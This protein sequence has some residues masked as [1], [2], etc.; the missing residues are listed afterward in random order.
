VF[1]CI[2]LEEIKEILCKSEAL[3]PLKP[4]I[5]NLISSPQAARNWPLNLVQEE[6]ILLTKESEKT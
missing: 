5:K 3:V 4:L 2:E 1:N 6:D